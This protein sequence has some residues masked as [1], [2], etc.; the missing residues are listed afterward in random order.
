FRGRVRSG[1]YSFQR[2]EESGVGRPLRY[3][4]ET[5]WFTLAWVLDYL[6]TYT[7]L[8]V[9][10]VTGEPIYEANPVAD[11][12]IDMLG[13]HGLLA[14]KMT[15]LAFFVWTVQWI[16]SRKPHRAKQVLWL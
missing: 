9:A 11:A 12:T 15:M 1:V 13:G 8:Y 14:F 5:C 3:E 7:L 2:Q 16:A 6:L 10:I 4:S